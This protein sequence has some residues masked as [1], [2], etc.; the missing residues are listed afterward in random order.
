VPATYNNLMSR[1]DLG[2]LIPEEVS[3]E[4]LGKATEE[5]AVLS[6]FRRVPVG[7]AQ[8]RFPVL[9]ALPTA[10]FVGGDTGLKQTTEINW[11]N[12]Y[13]NIEEIACIMPVPDNVVADIDANVWDEAMPLCV[14]AIGRTL[15]AAVFF[16]TNAPA[17]YPANIAAAAVA[18]GNSFAEPGTTPLGGVFANIDSTIG[19]AEA[20][21]FEVTG[22][23]AATSAK[24]QFRAAR[25]TTGERVDQ[26]RISG[27]LRSLDGFPILYPMRGLWPAA[28]G[29]RLFGGDWSQFVCAVRQD[30]TLRVSNEAVIQDQNGAIVYN[31]FQ[32]DLTFLRL[33]FRVGWQVANTIRNDQPV[34]ANR[35]PVASLLRYA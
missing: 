13:L 33:T 7:R 35:Y 2:A 28:P 22:Y 3:K 4:M 27:D 6:L 31:S 14:E 15:D 30:I 26:D 23:V 5:S 18:A 21:G 12:K 16:G 29:A 1:T 19:L 25:T 9:S 10:Y 32:Q 20:D 24:A 34:E 11:A 8:V 17:S